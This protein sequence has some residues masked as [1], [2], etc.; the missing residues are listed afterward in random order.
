MFGPVK[1]LG[2]GS[3]VTHVHTVSLL[4]HL[5]TVRKPAFGPV[6]TNKHG[7]K[8]KFDHMVTNFEEVD[9]E[10]SVMHM[11]HVTSFSKFL[12]LHFPPKTEKEPNYNPSKMHFSHLSTKLYVALTLYDL[13]RNLEKFDTFQNVPRLTFQ[14]Y[15]LVKNDQ[16]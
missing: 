7:S 10:R 8:A 1:K 9:Q 11:R 6:W 16:I 4:V 14:G 2:G 12:K 3:H 5:Q 15:N 13:D